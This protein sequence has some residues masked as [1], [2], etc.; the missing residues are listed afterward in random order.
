M[1]DA[2]II[3]GADTMF[4]WMA[5]FVR[6]AEL[7]C[8]GV[9]LAAIARGVGTP[10]HVYSA[11]VLADRYRRLDA[12][13]AG[14]PHRLHY[15]IKANATLAV[16]RRLRALGARADANSLGELEVARRA[17]FTPEDIVLTGVGKTIDEIRSA[18]AADLEAI[19]VESP[20]ELD[21][22]A[23]AA[24]GRKR[25]VR[26][27]IRLNP[28]VD[29]ETH[30]NITTGLPE[31]KFGVSFD[32]ARTM[33]R[34]AM[35][36]PAVRVVG[37]H[38]HV[39]SQITKAAPLRHVAR[40]VSELAGELR[41]AGVPLEHLDLGG[42]LGVAYT[43]N[44]AVLSEE[45]YAEA[46]LPLVRPTGLTLVLEPGRWLVAPAGVIVTTVVDL[47]RKAGGGWF[48]V[49]DAGMTD[50]LRPALYGAWH[51]IEPVRPRAGETMLADVVGPVCETSDTIGVERQLPALEIGDLLVIR[52]TGAYGA[53]MA[54]NYNR[55]PIAA[56]V[57]VEA[58]RSS[59]A[60][61]RQSIDDMLQWDT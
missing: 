18:V 27:A 60:R 16:V 28:N 40:A 24:R 36:E 13:F 38:A 51:E 29:A 49:V 6:E 5:G 37:L 9:S 20:G 35:A 43:P 58:G 48:V 30:P 2:T 41:A 61:R 26:V 22:I 15:A 31:T 4:D 23:A 55:R 10:V 39:G 47:K 21:R 53:V 32:E 57:I 11:A 52:D 3:A 7:M 12:A 54:S 46:L 33:I 1:G 19:N 34:R 42:G 50:L 56:E 59:L 14:Y 8:D 45:E 25:P 17:G 44:Q